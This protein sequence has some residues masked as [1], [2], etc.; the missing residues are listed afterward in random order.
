MYTV[1]KNMCHSGEA[2]L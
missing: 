2:I 1:G